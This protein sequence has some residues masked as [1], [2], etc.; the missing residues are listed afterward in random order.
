MDARA[1]ARA[2]RRKR[3]RPFWG[4]GGHLAGHLARRRRLPRG[5]L[6]VRPFRNDLDPAAEAR[7]ERR[8]IASVLR[9]RYPSILASWGRHSLMASGRRAG[10]LTFSCVPERHGPKSKSS[11]ERTRR[12]PTTSE[13]RSPFREN[14]SS[15]APL[16]TMTA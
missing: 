10:R 5:G 7:R 4:V 1:E 14:G 15:L 9:C 6:R 11:W 13:L 16:P 3:T 8:A 12:R 2:V